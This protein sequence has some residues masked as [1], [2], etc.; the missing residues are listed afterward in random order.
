MS[1]RNNTKHKKRID[2]RLKFQADE[3]TPEGVVFS[4]L[5][6]L[7]SRE[8]KDLIWQV[9]RMCVLPL[10]YK[11]R[12]DLSEEELRIVALEA[13]EALESHARDL[14]QLFFLERPPQPTQ[15]IVI[16]NGQGSV[17]PQPQSQLEPSK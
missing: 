6:S 5:N 11:K 16:M 4:Y 15:Q 9:L 13:C 2:F 10:A 3:D 14:R 17:S 7:G 12:G 8:S 1:D